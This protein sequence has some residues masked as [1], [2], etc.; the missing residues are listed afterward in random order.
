[1]KVNIPVNSNAT[2]QIGGRISSVFGGFVKIMA[3]TMIV[4]KRVLFL[5]HFW[6]KAG[7]AAKG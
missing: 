4:M 6:N 5:E 3:A 2:I 1:L 7:T